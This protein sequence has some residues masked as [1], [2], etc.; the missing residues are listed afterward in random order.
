MCIVSIGQNNYEIWWAI[1][2]IVVVVNC[3][4]FTPHLSPW[5]VSN[6]HF[7]NGAK[8]NQLTYQLVKQKEK[9]GW[10]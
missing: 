10:L 8:P 9:K 1:F 6:D 3:L 7:I 4:V 2:D 5:T